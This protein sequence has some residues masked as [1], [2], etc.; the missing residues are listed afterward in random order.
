MRIHL[1][2]HTSPEIEAGICYGQADLDLKP[3]FSEECEVVLSKSLPNYDLVVSSPLQRCARLAEFVPGN[4]RKL[5]D[6]IIEY[7]FGDWELQPW[8]DI[9]SA[10]SKA[11]MDDFV[12]VPAPNGESMAMMKLRV[13]EFFDEL[14][15]LDHENV[16]VVTHSGVQ[17]L[18]HARILQTPLQYM[19]R[20]QLEFGAVMELKNDPKS[21]LITIKHL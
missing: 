21:G 2:R 6:R 13:D 4:N 12:N 18:I 8:E 1:I 17:R 20:L 19:F 7:S 9:R 3:S 14:L 16:A 5:D 15:Q 11:W 10:E